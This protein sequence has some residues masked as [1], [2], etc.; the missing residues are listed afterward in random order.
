MRIL[1]FIFGKNV[2]R[3]W[4]LLSCFR[5][6]GSCGNCLTPQSFLLL[7][8]SILSELV[9]K[10]PTFYEQKCSRVYHWALSW[11]SES[12]P[13]PFSIHLCP[14][15]YMQVSQLVSLLWIFQLTLCM[16][17]SFPHTC[18]MSD[19]SNPWFDHPVNNKLWCSSLCNFLH[20][21]CFLGPNIIL[22]ILLN[23]SPFRMTDQVSHR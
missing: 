9:N 5:A 2:L 13:H 20:S 6:R 7:G 21:F 10:F 19:P 17:S 22:S 4:T 18:S 16:H 8:K 14:S 12:N 11:L 1:N 15:C 3:M 23:L